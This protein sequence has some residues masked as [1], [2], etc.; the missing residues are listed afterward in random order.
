MIGVLPVGKSANSEFTNAAFFWSLKVSNYENWKNEPLSKWQDYC[1]SLWPETESIVTQFKTHD[2]LTMA[3]YKD[4]ILKNYNHDNLVFIGDSAHCTSPQLGQG[5]NLALV[6]AYVLAECLKTSNSTQEALEQFNNRRKKH[7]KFY[8][9]ASRALTPF[10][11]SDSLFFAKLRLLA[12]GLSCKIPF[13]QKMAANVLT[14]TR[15]S[16]FSSLP[17][18]EWR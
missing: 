9:M 13:T 6:D 18:S 3:T 11:Q 8:Q 1:I 16:L 4:V 14:G 5:A 15:N 10:F 2:D 12:C 7:I 17:N